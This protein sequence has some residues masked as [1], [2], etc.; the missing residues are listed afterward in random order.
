MTALLSAILTALL[1][2][3]GSLDRCLGRITGAL[4]RRIFDG[5]DRAAVREEAD[6]ARREMW[7]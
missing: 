2:V 5:I 4:A 7:S 3:W 1:A 6:R